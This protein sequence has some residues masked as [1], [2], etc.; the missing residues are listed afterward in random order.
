MQDNYKYIDTLI[1]NFNNN[2]QL[3]KNKSKSLYLYGKS[4]IGK[5]T[6]VKN[7]LKNN[8]LD[9]LYYDINNLKDRNTF[10]SIFYN[11][12][13]SINIFNSFNKINNK[14]IFYIIDN[15]DHIQNNEKIF[16]GN[17]IKSIRPR[18]KS[19]KSEKNNKKNKKKINLNNNI[20]FIGTNVYEKKIKELIKISYF[21]EMKNDIQSIFKQE[22]RMLNNRI[23]DFLLNNNIKPNIINIFCNNNLNKLNLLYKIINKCNNNNI[24]VFNKLLNENQINSYNENIIYNVNKLLFYPLKYKNKIYIHDNDKTII[25]LL[26]HENIIDY[27]S[28]PQ[29]Y[30]F[31]KNFLTNICNG[32]YLDRVCFQK[33]IW[34]FNEMTYYLKIDQ[35]Y[36]EYNKLK[37]TK[38]QFKKNTEPSFNEEKIKKKDSRFTKVLTKYSTEYNN[39]NFIISL[40]KKLQVDRKNLFNLFA[41]NINNNDFYNDLEEYDI[42]KL[43]INRMINLI[44]LHNI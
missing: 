36:E 31:Y 27:L 35:N 22:N 13:G 6:I 16:L 34:I 44:N 29:D 3:D 12:N 25:S 1:N 4:G 43:D 15:I 14:K 23:N 7:I 5:T 37:I 24:N 19:K 2:I 9:Y 39:N 10:N 17:I 20:I 8:N 40:C 32:D 26:F 42:N 30:T 38:Q 33:Q 11:D 21:V 18:K 41:S 28:Q